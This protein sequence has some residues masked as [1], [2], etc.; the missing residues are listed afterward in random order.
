MQDY[1]YIIAA[2]FAVVVLQL[3]LWR[4]RNPAH[5]SLSSELFHSISDS[6]LVLSP[7]MYIR[8]ANPAFEKNF[9]AHKAAHRHYFTEFVH[10]DDRQAAIQL[11]DRLL[12]INVELTKKLRLLTR[13]GSYRVIELKF[14]CDAN[15]ANIFCVGRDVTESDEIIQ[16][17]RD[18]KIT[19]EEAAVKK[20]EF[21]AFMSH[22]VCLC[23]VVTILIDFKI[24]TP[25]NAVIG[26][27]HMLMD[28]NLNAEQQEYARVI[29]TSSDALLSVINDVL[30]VS[31]IESRKLDLEIRP[32]S[33][34]D[35][36]A[37]FRSAVC[38]SHE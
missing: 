28:S 37:A 25:I 30:D 1:L 29:H 32:F 16:T 26:M 21:I 11:W 18:E 10:P 34:V 4:R 20:Q 14:L 33:I 31:R 35:V 19:A 38:F 24:R 27:A 12:K 13:D 8:Q 5:N 23:I 17:L 3:V 6:M 2:V 36:R 22:E 7:D 15:K 9:S